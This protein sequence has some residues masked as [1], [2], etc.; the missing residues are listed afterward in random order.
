LT[1]F[2]VHHAQA[3]EPDVDP[4][5]PL[6]SDGSRHAQDLAIRARD[7]GVKPVVIWHSGKLRARQ[8]A[9]AFWKACNPLAEFAA[10]RGL[11]PT[12]PA[13]TIVDAVAGET[14]DI[15]IVGHFPSL[16]RI[17]ALLLGKSEGEPPDF[18]LH[19]MVALTGDGD[20]WTEG[21]RLV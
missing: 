3:T 4:Q 6:T 1:L 10:T 7:R 13:Q 18:P 20:R 11:Q 2:L 19:G 14:R 17:F 5:R 8:T 21:W 16:P 15:M 9:E 12:D